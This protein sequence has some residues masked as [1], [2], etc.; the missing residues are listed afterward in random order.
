MVSYG[1]G[2]SSGRKIES[3]GNP[4]GSW[5]RTRCRSNAG[6]F[7]FSSGRRDLGP[8][9]LFPPETRRAALRVIAL[10]PGVQPLRA[11]AEV[12]AIGKQL[13]QNSADMD[14]VDFTAVPQQEYC[15]NVRRPLIMI[16]V[17][18]GFLLAVFVPTS[19]IWCWPR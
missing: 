13:K 6:W 19:Q 9:K 4:F 15:R 1:F 8:K 12:S 3:V 16:F 18:V 11:R 14:T 7:C 17:V 5:T 2:K 10:R